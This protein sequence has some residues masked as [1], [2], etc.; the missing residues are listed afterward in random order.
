MTTNKHTMAL[1]ELAEKG[2]DVDLLREMIQFVAQRL[3][4]LDVETLCGPATVNA[5]TDNLKVHKFHHSEI[6]L[7][8]GR[9]LLRKFSFRLSFVGFGPVLFDVPIRFRRRHHRRSRDADR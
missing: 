7:F 1:A 5:V 9:R 3:M 4:E 8:L 2:A 6:A